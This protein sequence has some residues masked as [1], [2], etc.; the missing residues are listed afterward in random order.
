MADGGD[1]NWVKL[2]LTLRTLSILSGDS[3]THCLT[4]TGPCSAKPKTVWWLR[5]E[6]DQP[7]QRAKHFNVPSSAREKS[8]SE[9]PNPASVHAAITKRRNGF[10][11]GS[12]FL[13]GR[14][15][16]RKIHPSASRY[17][18]ARFPM[19]PS[20]L[21]LSARL[22]RRWRLRWAK[23]ASTTRAARSPSVSFFAWLRG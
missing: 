5:F 21:R 6:K 11:L 12:K 23:P 8:S 13:P 9:L 19:S 4:H 15:P 22:F 17:T 20:F 3:A 16:V 18:K 7:S 1:C 10:L 14:L 2:G